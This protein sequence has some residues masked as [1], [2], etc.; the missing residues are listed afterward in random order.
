MKTLL[1]SNIITYSLQPSNERLKKWL[2][3]HT[4]FISAITQLE[5]LGYHKITKDKLIFT[6]GFFSNGEIISIEQNVINKAIS[7]R[8]SKSM[9]VGDS[10][11]AATAAINK[12]SLVTANTKNFDHIKNLILVNPNEF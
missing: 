10:I 11:I 4:L 5:V 8:Q 1:D 3:N 12:F 7:F 9:S 6:Q 2:S